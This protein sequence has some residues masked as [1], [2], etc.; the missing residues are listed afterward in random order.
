[1]KNFKKQLINLKLLLLRNGI[2][3]GEYL[4]K[5]KIFKEFGKNVYFQPY[6]IPTQPKLVKIGN[7]VRIATGVLFLE[8]DVISGMLNKKYNTNQYKDFVGTIEIDDNTFVRRGV[9]LLANIKIGQNCIIGAGSVV[10]KDIPDNSIA[11]GNPAKVIGNV[12]QFEKQRRL[13]S[14]KIGSIDIFD[15]NNL[16]IF[17]NK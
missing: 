5:K 14:K 7:N 13:Y 3:R 16:E 17:W 12:E 11:V 4:E 15:D 6:K 1:M 2:K 10:T 8:H 9:I